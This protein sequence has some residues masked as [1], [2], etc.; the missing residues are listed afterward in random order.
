M[1]GSSTQKEALIILKKV[2]MIRL[3]T[4]SL[5]V[6]DKEKL[7]KELKDLDGVIAKLNKETAGPQNY[8]Q[9][10]LLLTNYIVD[11]F[12]GG[13]SNTKSDPGGATIYGLSER[14]NPEVREKI[15]SKTLT[16]KEAIDIYFKKYYSPIIG[17]EEINLGVAAVIYD[18][19]IHGSKESIEDVQR[20]LK[21]NFDNSIGVDGVYGR[22]TF[23]ALKKLNQN[24]VANLLTFLIKNLSSAADKAGDRVDRYQQ[25]NGLAKKNYDGPFVT[26]LFGRYS[27]ASTLIDV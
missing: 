14:F 8:S 20:F 19:I 12:E 15:R 2:L 25:A 7:V 13:F 27:F 24:D 3:S 9:R 6:V 17:I 18:S 10:F 16:K 11:N 1:T 23:N 21:I 5:D 26:R 4:L 22:N